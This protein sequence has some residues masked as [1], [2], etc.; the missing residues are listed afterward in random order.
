MKNTYR[1]EPSKDGEGIHIVGIDTKTNTV[2]MSIDG[3]KVTAVFK[4]SNNTEIYDRVKGI[5]IDSVISKSAAK[6]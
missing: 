2:A 3:C 5:L 4:E 6:I 1:S